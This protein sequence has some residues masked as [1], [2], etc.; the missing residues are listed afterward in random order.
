MSLRVYYEV[1]NQ[2]GSPA[3][4]TDTLANRPA[5][6][7]QGRLFISTD[8][9]QIYEDTGSAWS[10]IA[11]ATGS[12]VGFVPYSGAVNNLNLGTF[13]LTAD[14]GILNQVKAVG[15][16]G[17][18][19]NS[20]S[21]T[22]IAL[23]G[24]GGG[25][26]FTINGI[27][28]LGANSQL[29]FTQDASVVIPSAGQSGIEG[30][31]EDFNFLAATSGGFY[32]YFSFVT[33]GLT[34]NTLR[35]YTM[36]D[37]S[38]T[39][40]LTSNLS[41]YLPLAGG[42][43]TGALS[44]TSANF[45]GNV[46]IGTNSPL[47]RLQVVPATLSSTIVRFGEASGTTGKQLLFGI[48]STTGRGE[49]QSVWQGTSNTP[50]VLNLAGGN[51]GIGTGSVPSKLSILQSSDTLTNGIRQYRSNNSD[52]FETYITSGFGGLDDTYNFYSSFTAGIV[53][54][55]DRSGKGYFANNVLIGTTT[56]NGNKLQVTGAAYISNLGTGLVYSNGG[57]LTSTNPSDER[58]KS[59]IKEIQ[60]GLNE[61]LKL[62]PVTYNWKND[63]I[64]QG[65]QFGFIAQ[66]VQQIM[67]EAIKDIQN[68][69]LGLE[70]D[71]IYTTLIKAIQELNEKIERL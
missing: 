11:D 48:D 16:G 34:N 5:F 20:N 24:V 26:N 67:P 4:Y 65:I 31:N 7:F 37:A 14:I 62:R 18:S 6:G 47:S 55:I 70:K 1:L 21:G 12:V 30:V 59:N 42:T 35:S 68:K 56:D 53:A 69:F 61:I 23:L 3:L 49:I 46:G 45:S 41:S 36:P 63:K 71:A 22:Q 29:R 13:D 66:E 64:N 40:A 17:L 25:D 28:V 54:A 9:A 39:L 58:L 27:L 33:S 52:F 50:L 43:L 19:I 51:V 2:K 32:K 44:G 8:T 60:W 10:L 15:S 57:T 38:G